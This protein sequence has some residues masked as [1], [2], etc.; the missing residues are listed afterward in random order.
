MCGGGG[1]QVEKK[2]VR[3][4]ASRVREGINVPKNMQL[5]SSRF[6][7]YAK[8]HPQDQRREREKRQREG[9]QKEKKIT[10]KQKIPHHIERTINPQ[11]KH[12]I[13]GHNHAAE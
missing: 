9:G 3:V 2:A 5:L 1:V 6:I 13:G 11:T 4:I 7:E 8:T 12:T 10:P